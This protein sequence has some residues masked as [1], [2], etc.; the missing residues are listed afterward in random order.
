MKRM[1]LVLVAVAAGTL[2]LGLTG[3]SED[4]GRAATVGEE[5]ITTSDDVLQTLIDMK[6]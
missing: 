1:R 6:R 5:V 2:A 4:G 3:C